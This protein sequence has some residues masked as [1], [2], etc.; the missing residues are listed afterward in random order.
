MRAAIDQTKEENQYEISVADQF[1]AVDNDALFRCQLPGGQWRDAYQL[2][3][4]LEDGQPLAELTSQLQPA[5]SS[6]PHLGRSLVLPDGQLYIQRV[7]LRDANKSYR[8]QV[9][10]LLTGQLSMSPLSGR[11]FVT[12][13][14][15]THFFSLIF[16]FIHSILAH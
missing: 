13:E 7:Q 14:F 9:R 2:V 10:N 6:M 1:V 5:A 11:L 8:C 3:A 12:G 15:F 4:W 16:Y